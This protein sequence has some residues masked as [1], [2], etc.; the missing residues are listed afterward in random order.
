M[1]LRN[2]HIVTLCC[3]TIACGSNS[4]AMTTYTPNE[5]TPQNKEAEAPLSMFLEKDTKVEISFNENGTLS[6][7]AVKAVETS[8]LHSAAI[9]GKTSTLKNLLASGIFVDA[10]DK[11]HATALY[12]AALNGHVDTVNM[13][14]H[15]GANVDTKIS[16]V[17]T[18]PVSSE[19][20]SSSQTILDSV[21]GRI[22][23]VNALNNMGQ[24]YKKT[25][26]ADAVYIKNLRIIKMLLQ[27]AQATISP[28]DVLENEQ[29]NDL[30]YGIKK[31]PSTAPMAATAE[32]QAPTTRLCIIIPET[33]N[34][35]TPIITY[36]DVDDTNVVPAHARAHQKPIP[37]QDVI[38]SKEPVKASITA[39]APT[40]VPLN[41]T[42]ET[43]YF[44]PTTAATVSATAPS[45]PCEKPMLTAEEPEEYELVETE[46]S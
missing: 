44:A 16:P 36:Q 2:L 3:L 32:Q 24:T 28:E 42:T 37:T 9:D 10:L 27:Q 15:F 39:T 5:K 26:K 33:P 35:T 22:T 21:I 46:N 25:K 12:Y 1:K 43:N 45:A 29:L 30:F 14:L 38:E 18:S 31:A 11:D 20:H 34:A 40:I 17:A 13:L 19:T 7:N 6:Y 23:V 8:P 41:A 4:N